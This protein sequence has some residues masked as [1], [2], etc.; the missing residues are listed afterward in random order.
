MTDSMWPASCTSPR[1]MGWPP[2]FWFVAFEDGETA[3][4]YPSDPTAQ[5]LFRDADIRDDYELEIV[6]YDD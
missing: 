4:Y 1:R 5:K 6:W 2:Y 3:M